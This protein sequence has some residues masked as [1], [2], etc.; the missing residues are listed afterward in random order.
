MK[1]SER[2]RELKDEDSAWTLTVGLVLI[3][4]NEVSQLESEN[5]ALRE[6]GKDARL[7]LS[8]LERIDRDSM[9]VELKSAYMILREILN[10]FDRHR[11]GRRDIDIDALLTGEDNEPA[12]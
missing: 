12:P 9:G 6:I 5:E 4:A 3:W 1:L 10:P 7:A 11:L 2:M 8:E